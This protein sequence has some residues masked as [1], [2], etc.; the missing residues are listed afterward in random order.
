MGLRHSIGLEIL[1][2]CE[3]CLHQL[4]KKP[5]EEKVHA[6]PDELVCKHCKLTIKELIKNDSWKLLLVIPLS[7]LGVKFSQEITSISNVKDFLSQF[8][9]LLISPI[10][11]TK[12]SKGEQQ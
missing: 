10:S 9:N 12:N 7:A 3:D 11:I 5:T 4:D 2:I 6:D 8:E 1:N